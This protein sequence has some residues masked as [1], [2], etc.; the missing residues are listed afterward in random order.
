MSPVRSVSARLTLL[1]FSLSLPALA[2]AQSMLPSI[3]LIVDDVGNHLRRGTTAV[4]LPGD[5]TLAVLPHTA[6]AVRLAKLA[7]RAGKEVLVHLPMEPRSRA[8]AGPGQ[9]TTQMG[10]GEFKDAVHRNLNAIPHA[11][12]FNNHMG[13]R[14]TASPLRMRWLME[15]VNERLEPLVAIDSKTTPNSVLGAL[16]AEYNVEVAERDIFVDSRRTPEAIRQALGAL[17][18]KA[19]RDGFALG[20]AHPYPETLHILRQWAHHLPE[21]GIRLVNISR[22]IAGQRALELTATKPNVR[23]IAAKD[24]V[25]QDRDTDQ[26]WQPNQQRISKQLGPAVK[27]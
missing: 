4:D 14:I 20:I 11:V 26:S 21:R 10:E 9:L 1:L 13:S 18:A 25:S 17:E 3:A 6:H 22:L 19:Q 8:N 16:A 15:A 24:D 27:F 2:S 5:F 12:G 23:S 7:H